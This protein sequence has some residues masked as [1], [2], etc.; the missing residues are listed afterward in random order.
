MF[1]TSVVLQLSLFCYYQRDRKM[2]HSWNMSFGEIALALP[3]LNHCSFGMFIEVILPELAKK[4]GQEI[5][6]DLV[7]VLQ[8][9]T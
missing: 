8:V 1:E 3:D 6:R 7:I 5:Y 2:P 4:G 9:V